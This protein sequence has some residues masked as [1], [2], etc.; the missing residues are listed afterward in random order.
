MI[1]SDKLQKTVICILYNHYLQ[2]VV[3]QGFENK[4][5]QAVCQDKGISYSEWDSH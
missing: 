4:R 2:T 5:C 3:E 1:K